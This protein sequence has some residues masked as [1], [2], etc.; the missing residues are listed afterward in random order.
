MANLISL[1]RILLVFVSAYLIFVGTVTSF[2]SALVVTIIVFIL[3]G[4]DGYVARLLHEE[5]KLGSVI[6]II[7]DRIVENAYWVIFAVLGWVSVIFPLISLTRGFV[8]DGLRSVALSQ[9]YTAFGS[10]SMQSSKIGYLICSSRVT[11]VLYAVAKVLAFLLLI[12]ANIPLAT[13]GSPALDVTANVFAIIAIV[14][15][16]V[17][18]IPVLVESK[19]FF[20]KE[21]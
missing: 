5:S 1:L 16:V 19:K 18:A 4:V 9:G 14:F 11:R 15:C 12:I 2:I 7:G 8:T 17:R 13:L 10:D 20:K 3:D 6:D 21:D